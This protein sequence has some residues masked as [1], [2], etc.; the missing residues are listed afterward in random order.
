[1]CSK[2]YE[3]KKR[4]LLKP[5]V[6]ISTI[7][8]LV[9]ILASSV[10]L[11][12]AEQNPSITLEE[13]QITNNQKSDSPDIF[14]DRIVYSSG[15][16]D[17]P[18]TY[19]YKVL[20]S[21]EIQ[22]TNNGSEYYP[23][24]Y[25]DNIVYE[26]HL[27]DVIKVNHESD[28]YM[29]NFYTHKETRITYSGSAYRPKIYGDKIV[30]I[31]FRNSDDKADV[32]MYNLSTHKETRITTSKTSKGNIAIYGDRI[33]WEEK[34]NNQDKYI[35]M[36]NTLTTKVTRIAT[37]QNIEYEL[38]MGSLGIFDDK[39]VYQ[40]IRNGKSGIYMYNISTSKET[41]IYESG[42]QDEKRP[43]I[44]GNRIVWMESTD[45]SK[46]NILM[47]DLTTKEVS[48]ITKP[49]AYATNP[50]IYGNRIVWADGCNPKGYDIYMATLS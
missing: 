25:D 32:Y 15:D 44:Y 38:W 10:T 46:W 19:L 23:S 36:F 1:M 20:T 17:K 40:D 21:R 29:Y 49:G 37:H 5:Q 13:T 45:D 7:F 12:S 6:G 39:V 26:H 47:Y 50:V 27:P 42:V 30:W 2:T 9:F 4:R 3:T 18:N 8:V 43:D 16:Y 24:I 31:D 22:I 33:V 11:V 48:R 34:L 35:F 14:I 41:M 28:I